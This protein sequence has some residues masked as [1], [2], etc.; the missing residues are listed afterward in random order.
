MGDEGL[1]FVANP[2]ENPASS[3]FGGNYSGHIPEFRGIDELIQHWNDLPVN[4]RQSLLNFA[5][6]LLID[7]P[8]A[9]VAATTL[10][11]GLSP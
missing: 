4:S 9:S 8:T 11:N 6:Q 2:L 3:G 10:R 5:R 1:E 7:E